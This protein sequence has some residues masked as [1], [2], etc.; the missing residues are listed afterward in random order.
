MTDEL[1]DERCEHV[2]SEYKYPS[3]WP[4]CL[5]CDEKWPA[6]LDLSEAVPFTIPDSTSPDTPL[7][8]AYDAAC[9][10]NRSLA[11]ALRSERRAAD[12]SDRQYEMVLTMHD[13]AVAELE[14]ERTQNRFDDELLRDIGIA[15]RAMRSQSWP[16][17]MAEEMERRSRR[18]D[19]F[20]AARA[21]LS[22][23]EADSDER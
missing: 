8:R 6:D 1:T 21:A 11:A 4:T 23:Q 15:S 9:E 13:E 7:E 19:A 20:L 22:T 18:I 12:A 10:R 3:K 16:L 14:R 2:W 5:L 17:D